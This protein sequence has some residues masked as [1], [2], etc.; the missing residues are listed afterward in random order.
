MLEV[1][2]IYTNRRQKYAVVSEQWRIG[3]NPLNKRG[4]EVVLKVLQA[5][6]LSLDCTPEAQKRNQ[7]AVTSPALRCWLMNRS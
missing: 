7:A 3:P 1:K 2:Q 5:L 4:A 6:D